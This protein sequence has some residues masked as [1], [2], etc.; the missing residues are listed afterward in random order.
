MSKED[1]VGVQ[2]SRRS[3]PRVRHAPCTLYSRATSG[4]E[5]AMTPLQ[6]I[7]PHQLDHLRRQGLAVKLID[8]RTPEEFHRL[9]ADL[10]VNV[11]LTRLDPGR[12][13][14]ETPP[15][16]PLYVLSQSDT[17]GRQACERLRSAGCANVVQVEGGREAW[18]RAGLPVVR[19]PETISLF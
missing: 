10:A 1:C 8:T 4:K 16:V 12:L 14:R 17:S 2:A 9:H 7:T 15:D 5:G 11:P 6:T 13:T 19:D 18:E 3:S